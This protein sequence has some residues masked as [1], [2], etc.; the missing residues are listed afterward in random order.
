MDITPYTKGRV[1]C[2]LSLCLA[3]TLPVSLPA[4][5]VDEAVVTK[6]VKNVQL[7]GPASRAAVVND[8]VVNGTGVQTGAESW[9]EL[10][11]SSESVARLSPNSAFGLKEGIRRLELGDGAVLLQVP[12]KARGARVAA[13]DIAADVAGTTAVLEFHKTVY[14]FFVLEGTARFSRPHHVGESVLVRPGQMVIGTPD[15]ALGDPVDFDIARFLKTSKFI[16]DF[17][18]LRSEARM[19]DA[20]RKQDKLKSKKKL[21]ETNLVIFGG[22]TNVSLTEIPDAEKKRELEQA[23][24]APAP[25]ATATPIINSATIDRAMTRPRPNPNL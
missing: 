17:P 3:I 18:P 11:F 7:T 20:S 13:A 6:A 24:A 4:R 22:G 9:A 8:K 10:T 23:N 2:F 19:A 16:V 1:G 5:T 21:I 14:K 15:T 12:K 25:S